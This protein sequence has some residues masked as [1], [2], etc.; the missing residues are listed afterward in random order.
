MGPYPQGGG[1]KAAKEGLSED[2]KY[3]K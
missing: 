3:S 2:E 1:K